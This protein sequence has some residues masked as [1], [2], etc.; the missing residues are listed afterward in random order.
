[1]ENRSTEIFHGI[2]EIYEESGDE[3]EAPET[4]DGEDQTQDKVEYLN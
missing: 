1:M 4:D 2:T 3:L